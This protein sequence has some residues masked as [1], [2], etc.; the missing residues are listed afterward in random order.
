[1]EMLGLLRPELGSPRMLL[2]VK[3]SH[4]VVQIQEGE[5]EVSATL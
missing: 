1:M 4:K 2:V 3:A 5:R